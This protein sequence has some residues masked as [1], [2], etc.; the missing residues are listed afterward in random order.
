MSDSMT[1]AMMDEHGE[2]YVSMTSKERVDLARD[3]FDIKE[4]IQ[5]LTEK[6]ERI[7]SRLIHG[8]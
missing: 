4:E 1:T 2:A 7:L 8:K 6:L 3:A 5:E